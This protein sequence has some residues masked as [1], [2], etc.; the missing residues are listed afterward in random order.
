MNAHRSWIVTL[1]SSRTMSRIVLCVLLG[2]TTG[3]EP[4]AQAQATTSI[5][6]TNGTGNLDTT[7]TPTG[8]LYNI[9][10]GTRA[11]TNLFHSFGNFTVGAA[12]T[13]NFLNTPVNGSLPLTTNILGR[14]TGGNP[15]SIFGTVQT[16]GFGNANLFLMNPAGFLFGPNATVNVGGMV[17][18]T[19]ADYLKLTDN[20]R[21]NAIPNAT[22]DALLSASPVAAFG[23]LGSIPGAI[24]VQGSQFTVTDRSGISLVGGNIAIQ[25]GTLEDTTVQ[26]AIL[27]AP[28]GQI[29]LVSAASPGEVLT[30]NFDSSA[31]MTLGSITLSEGTVLNVSAN[32]AGTIRIR[33]GQFMITDAS[34]SADTG[35]TN[36]APVAIGINVTEDMSLTDTRG[37]PVIAARTNGS[38]DA[39]EI[40]ISSGNLTATSSFV[41]P[42][43]LPT[44]LIDSH[45]LGEGR[46]GDV[47]ITTGNLAVSGTTTNSFFFIDSGTAG[48]GR[49][50]N[51]TI[52][53]ETVDLDVT[54]ISTGQLTA[55]ALLADTSGVNGSAGNVTI[56]ADTFQL[57]NSVLD[58]SATL[59]QSEFQKGG[60]ITITARDISMKDTQVT[61]LAF[62]GGGT[63][64]I[65]ADR[66]VTDFTS[67]ETDTVSGQGGA[68]SVEAH[69]VELTNGSSL[70]STTFGDG[71]AGN[72]SLTAGN[73]VKILGDLGTNPQAVF[74]PSGLFSNSFG[75]LGSQGNAGDVIVTTPTIEMV[76]GRINTVTA[77]SGQGGNVTLNVTDSISISGEFPSDRLIVPSIF[78]IGPLAP[79]GIV[80]S[81]V[82]SEFCAGPCGNAGN[83]SISTGSLSMASGSQINSGTNSTGNGGLITINTSDT[84]SLSGRLSNGSPV[85][86]FSSSI[87]A[88]PDAGS[89]GNITLTTG[90]SFTVSNGASVSA[91]STGPGNA[92]NITV[93]AGQS[94]DLDD[95]SIKTEAAQASGGNIDIQAI[96]QVRLVNS[97]ISTTVLGG[98]GSG[99]NITIDPNVVVLQNSQVIAQAVQGAGGNIT[100]TTPLFLAD[101]TSL[102][103]ASSQFGLN[104]T[105]TIQSPTSNLSG[106]LGTLSSKTSQ[107]QSLLT[108]RCAALANGQASSFV[109]AGREQLPSD[110]GSWLTSPL[111]LAGLDADPFKDGTVAEGDSNLAPRTSGL[112]ANDRVSLRRLTP[113]GFL[114][115]NFADSEAT[116]CHS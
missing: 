3:V 19:S 109:V 116:G 56:T 82:G 81:T 5:T 40:R 33:G 22:A 111:A 21:F 102:V 113:A 88:E 12:D 51:V 104:G 48:N 39:G 59:G 91:S 67:F 14:V 80:T 99:G 47:H 23:F 20:A 8:P 34:L 106:S 58:T 10:G 103:S 107:A 100:I 7:I 108:Q 70:I 37:V 43:F 25:S 95:S 41:D 71:N 105:V 31:N 98:A 64:T 27:S 83:V 89:G 115:A 55:S 6:P 53:A 24:T 45:T 61:S 77:S 29:N 87:G 13:A 18:F 44:T 17:A 84:I 65:K 42:D 15:S 86:V 30:S 72:I 54:S 68:I 38:G 69:V 94:L 73:H 110:P 4:L 28:G 35:N 101:S 63:F 11:G 2:A 26:P 57:K 90:Q 1:L 92:G 97:T 46:G 36:G 9:T 79:S 78:D 114:I 62:D 60:D 50:G 75:F 49:G 85:G 66:L 74:Q 16:T 52:N 96:D 76:A 112:L 93:N 32:T